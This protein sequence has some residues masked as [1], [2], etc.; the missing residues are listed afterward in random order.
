MIRQGPFEIY[1]FGSAS[2][3]ELELHHAFWSYLRNVGAETKILYLLD[4]ELS[5]GA[6]RESRVFLNCF[7]ETHTEIVL[8]DQDP[9]YLPLSEPLVVCFSEGNPKKIARYLRTV[10]EKHPAEQPLI[11]LG[12]GENGGLFFDY[13]LTRSSM[14]VKLNEGLAL[15]DGCGYVGYNPAHRDMLEQCQQA[16]GT[17]VST[18]ALSFNGILHSNHLT[19]PEILTRPG[20]TGLYESSFS[21][22]RCYVIPWPSTKHLNSQLCIRRAT[23]GDIQGILDAQVRSIRQ[24]VADEYGRQ[25]QW[26]LS[27]VGEEIWAHYCRRDLVWVVEQNGAIEGYAHLILDLKNSAS[28][29]DLYLTQE[30]SGVGIGAKLLGIMEQQAQKAGF[31]QVKLHTPFK[32]YPF[33]RK[34]GY[35]KVEMGGPQKKKDP[36]I[37]SIHM[38]KT[39]NF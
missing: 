6:K 11:F 21:E 13:Y 15:L 3:G 10:Q 2:F 27:R 34:H 20:E 18:F 29:N 30:V 32:S 28:I 26:S 23:N 25:G 14:E 38:I 12:V 36:L 17:E 39:F 7:G 5:P 16:L 33:Y 37:E 4:H 8:L 24:S 31:N 19:E 1:L 22:G 35:E 9:H